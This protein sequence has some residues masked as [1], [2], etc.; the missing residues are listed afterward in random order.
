[1]AQLREKR[2]GVRRL[3]SDRLRL[4]PDRGNLAG[5][6]QR[7]SIVPAPASINRISAAA[8]RAFLGLENIAYVVLG[9]LLA[10]AA[11]LGV[12]GAA[13]SLWDAVW[14]LGDGTALILAIDRLL[15]VLMVVEI[16]HTVRVS[17][18][19]GALVCEPF[20]IVGLIASIRRILMITLE[21]SQANQPGKWSP[22]SE[23]MLRATMLELG[24]LSVLI[25][26]MVISIYLL[27]R[28]RG[29]EEE[30]GEH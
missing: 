29:G 13:T 28:R 4:A 24:V 21:A 12:V 22:Q 10:I 20:L 23:S 3:A 11:L 30:G 15:F 6:T 7:Q 17:F 18:R 27:R 26:V 8:S 9:L 5:M 1:M 25:L 19:S 16:L 14:R 2:R